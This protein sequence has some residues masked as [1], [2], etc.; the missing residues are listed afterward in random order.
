MRRLLLLLL[1][2]S[3][4]PCGAQEP[5]DRDREPVNVATLTL[6]GE[7]Y[8]TPGSS[9][10]YSGP[11]FA[12]FPTDES[13]IRERG[14]LKDGTWEGLYESFYFNGEVDS[15]I[16]YQDGEFHGSFERY[17]FDGRVLAK[18]GYDMGVRCGDWSDEGGNDYDYPPCPAG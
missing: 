8:M 6:E 14:I 15:R 12:T 2:L 10:P 3:V 1:S 5:S 17:Y 7:L 16:H 9:S 13:R 4:T 11:A 18:G